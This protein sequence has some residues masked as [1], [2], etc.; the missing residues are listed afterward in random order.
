[1]DDGG[2]GG[3]GDDVTFSRP[4]QVASATVV[5]YSRQKEKGS[6]IFDGFRPLKTGWF[7]ICFFRKFQQGRVLGSWLGSADMDVTTITMANWSSSYSSS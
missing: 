7:G 2:G 5:D 1:G 4:R 6:L 3:G